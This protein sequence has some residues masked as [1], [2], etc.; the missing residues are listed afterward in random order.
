[1]AEKFDL[2]VHFHQFYT[3]SFKPH[4]L[5]SENLE[6]NANTEIWNTD[7]SFI[8]HLTNNLR[9]DSLCQNIVNK[10]LITQ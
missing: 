9:M 8:A 4:T 1:M 7:T 6:M 5:S 10:R 2:H 3:C